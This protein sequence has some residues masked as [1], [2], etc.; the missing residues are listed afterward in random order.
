MSKVKAHNFI[1]FTVF[2]SGGAVLIIEILGTRI[3]SPFFGSTIFVWSSLISV[4]L[5]FLALGYWLGGKASGSKKIKNIDFFV[6]IL[7]LSGVFINIIPKVDSWVLVETDFLGIRAGPLVAS[8]V[9]FSLPLT[10]LGMLSPIAIKFQSKR[11]AE[12][13]SKSGNIFAYSTVG[14]LFGSLLAGFFLIPN[15]PIS[16]IFLSTGMTLVILSLIWMFLSNKSLKYYMGLILIYILSFGLSGISVSTPK[17]ATIV[18][19]TSSFFGDIKIY[20]LGGVKNDIS[21]LLIDTSSQSCWN[22]DNNSSAWPYT[23]YFRGVMNFYPKDKKLDILVIGLG[24]GAVVKELA[25]TGHNIDIVEIDQNVI[26]IAKSYFDLPTSPNFNYIVSDGRYYI[27]TTN[28]KYDMV[29]VDIV[30]GSDP[31]LHL[32]TKEFYEEVKKV[33]KPDGVVSTNAM[34]WVKSQELQPI[35]YKTQKSVFP[36]V[37][38][39]VRNQ[40]GYGSVVYFASNREF[41]EEMFEGTVPNL[42]FV[43]FFEKNYDFDSL[44]I[45]TDDY[46]PSFTLDLPTIIYGR[47]ITIDKYGKEFYLYDPNIKN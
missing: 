12:V 39:S 26:R 36:F 23:R 28:K 4:A 15:F 31:S 24:G 30:I 20:T 34:G 44:Y 13:G 9:L 8:I 41:N 18:N 7:L 5:G 2:I 1:Y 10:L 6:L 27:R 47:N 43:D 37:G 14:S 35:I 33:L 38:F 46:N 22:N 29:M 3:L 21:C 25:D 11:L 42:Y 19:K 45:L 16:K 17:E 32:A 40:D